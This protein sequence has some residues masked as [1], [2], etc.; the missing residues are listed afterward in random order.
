MGIQLEVWAEK[1]IKIMKKKKI[2]QKDIAPAMGVKTRG[3]VSHYF[4]GRSNPTTHQLN[5]LANCLGV[6]LN[7][8]L[9]KN[10]LLK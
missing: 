1:A 8:L 6:S 2:S 10:H 5:G 4:T 9:I 3:A 7:H